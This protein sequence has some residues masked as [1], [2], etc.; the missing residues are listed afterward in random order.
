LRGKNRLFG[1]VL[2]WTTQLT[3]FSNQ[4]WP[5]EMLVSV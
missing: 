4:N 3:A 5:T 2:V 1:F